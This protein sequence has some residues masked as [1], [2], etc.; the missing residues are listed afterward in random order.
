MLTSVP[1]AINRSARQVVLRHPN[2][3]DAVVSRKRLVRVEPDPAT[4][5][6]SEMGGAPTMGGMGVLR[7]EDEAEFDYV[8]L[9]P[10]KLQFAG[11]GPFQQQDMI[12]R[13]NGLVPEAQ[14][15]VLIECIAEPGQPGYFLTDT[16]DLVMITLGPGVVMAYEVAN[17]GGSVNIPPY[18]RRL[19]LNP[20][21]DLAY[22][23]PFES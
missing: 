2:S 19:A 23:E 21:D 14:R 7:A 11:P 3:F 10:A 4:G 18:T 6:P 15:E 5:L 1:T 17:V 8:E 13:D 9:G 22:I 20:R 16:A 12:E